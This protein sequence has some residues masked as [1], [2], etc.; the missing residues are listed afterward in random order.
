[1]LI[2][3]VLAFAGITSGA[4]MRVANPQTPD[5]ANANT[6]NANNANKGGGTTPDTTNANNANK[7][8]SAADTRNAINA[9]T[10][11]ASVRVLKAYH[12]IIAPPTSRDDAK[13]PAERTTHGTE[14]ELGDIV[15]VEVA[16]L[17]TLLDDAKAKNKEVVLFLD[18]RPLT[19]VLAYPPSNPQEGKLRFPL[20]RTESTREIWTYLLG[21]PSWEPVA[22]KVSVGVDGDAAIPS[23]SYLELR[24]IPIGW[25]VFW[26]ILF[27][28][29]FVVFISLAARSDLLRDP[30][31]VADKSARRPYSLARTQVA[32]W[33]FLTLASY[34]LIGMVTGDFSTSITG[35]V[36]GLLGISTGTAMFSAFIDASKS[37]PADR[38]ERARLWS[39]TKAE[40]AQVEASEPAAVAA[41]SAAENA[42][43]ATPDDPQANEALKV[44]QAELDTLRARK[45]ALQSE[46]S[47]LE[48]KSQGLLLDLL[49]DANGVGFHRFQVLA[50]TIVLGIIFVAQVYQNLAMPTFDATLLALM[51]ISA[52]TYLGLK[53]PED[54][55]PKEP[56]ANG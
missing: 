40:L 10:N 32:L 29:L 34:L 44:R 14:V 25:F 28:I 19:N 56:A 9:N 4:S 55:V 38:Q 17:S 7:G 53:I 23:T 15:T 8:D 49:S 33:F 39:K 31:P 1:M 13:T 3:L 16:N 27:A 12:E 30:V 18:D 47:T 46:L 52:G 6:T 21:K 48:Y 50:W 20:R 42:Q 43:K 54:T 2:A 36:L 45:T 11:A 22:R 24:V 26:L 5:G 41:L 51:G 35:T 37:G